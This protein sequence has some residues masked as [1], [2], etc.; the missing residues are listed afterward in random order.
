MS[1]SVIKLQSRT[2][3]GALSQV[4]GSILIGFGFSDNA[5]ELVDQVLTGLGAAMQ[6]GGFVWTYFGRKRANA[7]IKVV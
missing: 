1:K 5:P 2:M 7:D 6:I 3:N 4:I